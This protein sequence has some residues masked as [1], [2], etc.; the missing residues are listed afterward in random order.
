V[1]FKLVL[2]NLKN[3]VFECRL[4]LG[5]HGSLVSLLVEVAQLIGIFVSGTAILVLV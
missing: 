3:F 5:V 2:N 1:A 4:W